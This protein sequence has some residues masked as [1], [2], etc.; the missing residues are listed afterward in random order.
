MANSEGFGVGDLDDVGSV[1]EENALDA[2]ED[3]EEIP[4]RGDV[5]IV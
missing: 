1:Q 4:V 2:T 3:L 5:W